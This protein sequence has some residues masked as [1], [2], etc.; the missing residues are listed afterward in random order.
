MTNPTIRKIVKAQTHKGTFKFFKEGKVVCRPAI[1]NNTNKLLDKPDVIGI[2]TGITSKAGGCLATSFM[3]D[4]RNE[5][6]IVVL[7]CSST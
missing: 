3:L 1:W 2:K 4:N 6:F 7:G 5:A